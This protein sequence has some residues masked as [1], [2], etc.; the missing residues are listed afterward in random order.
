MY[1]K[2]YVHFTNYNATT[3]IYCSVH[4]DFYLKLTLILIITNQTK[5]RYNCGSSENPE[6]KKYIRCCSSFA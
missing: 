2:R 1:I 5:P 3:R 6:I 4:S